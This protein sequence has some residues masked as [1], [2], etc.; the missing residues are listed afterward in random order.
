MLY[1]NPITFSLS[2]P[3]FIYFFLFLFWRMY[4]VSADAPHFNTMIVSGDMQVV[5]KLK[6]LE[7]KSNF[8]L[9]KHNFISSLRQSLISPVAF[10]FFHI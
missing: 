2:L 5:G 9:Q 10:H 4:V 7:W 6:S 1:K 3:F 8:S